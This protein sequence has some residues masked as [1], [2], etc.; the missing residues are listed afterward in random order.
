MPKILYVLSACLAFFFLKV[1]REW[2]D[3][4]HYILL[5]DSFQEVLILKK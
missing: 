2:L 4:R 5:N 1:L 3:I